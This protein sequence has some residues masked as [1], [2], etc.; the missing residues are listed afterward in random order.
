[1]E[2][3]QFL[4]LVN[5]LHPPDAKAIID[6]VDKLEEDLRFYRNEF[7]NAT[8]RAQGCHHVWQQEYQQNSYLRKI[9]SIL[10]DIL[11]YA[12]IKDKEVTTPM[13]AT[14]QEHMAEVEKLEKG[15]ELKQ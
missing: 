11:E 9:V 8:D 1:M 7:E 4:K 13:F 10:F 5:K 2:R 3:K 12:D 15:G 14:I 6:L